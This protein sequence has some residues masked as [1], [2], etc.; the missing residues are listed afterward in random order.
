MRFKILITGGSGYLA[1][2]IS[3]YLNQKN[4]FE[5]SVC[6]TVEIQTKKTGIEYLKIDWNVLA[7]IVEICKD[8][9]IIIH[10]A[11]PNAEDCFLNQKK[12]YDFNSIVLNEF[13]NQAIKQ[14]VR[15]FIYFSS[16]HVYGDLKKE[17]LDEKSQTEP[18][19]PYGI[20]KKIAEQVLLKYKDKNLIDINIIRL[21]NVFGVPCNL[22][23]KGWNL[24]INDFCKQAILFNE[25]KL[26]SDG[27]KIRNFVSI[28]EVCRLIDFMIWK[29]EKSEILPFVFNFGGD[30][31]SSITDIAYLI[32]DIFSKRFKKIPFRKNNQKTEYISKTEF[33]FNYDLIKNHGYMPKLNHKD[34]INLIFDFVKK[35]VLK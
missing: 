12:A 27:S 15:K 25:I 21:S 34:E 20:S 29:H 9:D 31:T 11:S 5:I 23:L 32:S 30:L 18:N 22:N 35:N 33:I 16:F 4:S 3:N 6:S 8:K 7:S 17:F 10:C 24:V 2:C 26:N 14:G 1:G 19:H 13:I 28:N